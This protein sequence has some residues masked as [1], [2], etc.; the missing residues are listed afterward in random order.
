MGS[1]TSYLKL[2]MPNKPKIRRLGVICTVKQLIL[3][4]E[5]IKG[6]VSQNDSKFN[7]IFET[8]IREYTLWKLKACY[9]KY[10]FI[11]FLTFLM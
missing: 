6:K 3:K 5:Y 7:Y 10:Q 1:K 11:F 2:L 4:K 9:F 8:Y